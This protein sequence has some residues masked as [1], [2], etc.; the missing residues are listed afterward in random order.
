M[1][2]RRDA[3]DIIIDQLLNEADDVL[4]ELFDNAAARI[5]EQAPSDAFKPIVKP[6]AGSKK[7]RNGTKNPWWRNYHPE[8]FV[9]PEGVPP[10]PRPAPASHTLYDDLEVSRAAS[11]ETISAAFRSLSQRFHPDVNK[12]KDAE[13]RMKRIT[14]AWAVLKNEKSREK[15][16]RSLA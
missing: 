11:H 13:E 8:D 3:L 4:T 16:D 6:R 1:P 2:P 15:Y 5:R 12:G 7:K 14:A 9:R 10:P